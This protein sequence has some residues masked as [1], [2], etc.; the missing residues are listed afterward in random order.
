MPNSTVI[1]LKPADKSYNGRPTDYTPELAQEICEAIA[2][3]SKGVKKLCKE[4]PHWPSHDAIYRWIY[5]YP[6]FY[7]LY[8]RAKVSQISVIVDEMFDVI[9]ETDDVNRARLWIDTTKWLT[10]KLVPKVYGNKVETTPETGLTHAQWLDH[11]E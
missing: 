4:N 5:I 6:D 1:N 10:C 11:L 2:C 3:S 8:T 7:D 9:A